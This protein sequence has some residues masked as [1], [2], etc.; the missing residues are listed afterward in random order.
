VNAPPSVQFISPVAEE[1]QK[2]VHAN[3][4]K[5]DLTEGVVALSGL[6]GAL[7]GTPDLTP[8]D[9]SMP[10]QSV[11][12]QEVSY[13][14]S[15]DIQNAEMKVEGLGGAA[16]EVSINMQGKEAQVVFRTDE[17]Q[18]REMLE[19]ASAHLKDMLGQEGVQ[20]TGV[21]VG[22]SGSGDSGPQDRKFRPG[23]R[24]ELALK[25]QPA[26]LRGGV[27]TQSSVGRTLDLYV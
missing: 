6:S 25:I 4:A 16:V 26:E 15:Q 13:Y 27:N 24:T 17:L 19:N 5:T 12:A 11:V 8:V 23:A 1:P 21:F 22:T 7:A 2:A 20:L 3:H 18:T 14:I 10:F 9:K